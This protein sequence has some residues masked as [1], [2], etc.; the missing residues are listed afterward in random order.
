MKLEKWEEK[1]K[2]KVSLYTNGPPKYQKRPP[3]MHMGRKYNLLSSEKAVTMVMTMVSLSFTY[4]HSYDNFMYCHSYLPSESQKI[5]GKL[6]VLTF[7]AI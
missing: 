4:C 2:K 6:A 5:R 3:E 7:L 1:K